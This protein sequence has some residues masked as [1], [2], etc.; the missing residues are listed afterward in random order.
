VSRRAA[1]FCALALAPISLRATDSAVKSASTAPAPANHKLEKKFE[2]IFSKFLRRQ[3]TI[4]NVTWR[5][6]P[7]RY[8]GTG[9]T[10]WE[11]PGLAMAEGPL[12]TFTVATLK[13]ITSFRLRVSEM[14]FVNA[15]GTLRFDHDGYVN[16]VSMIKDLGEY[17]HKNYKHGERQKVVYGSFRIENARVH[18]IDTDLGIEPFGAPLRLDARGDISGIGPKT[19]FPFHLHALLQSPQSPMDVSV[20]GTMS[21]WPMIR[22]SAEHIPLSAAVAYLPV[23]RWFS[24]EARASADF[25]KAGGYVF[26][27]WG[28]IAPA[29]KARIALPFPTIRVDAL[30]HEYAPSH[31]NVTLTGKATH[32]DA[33]VNVHDFKSKRIGFTL[34]GKDADIDECIQ[35]C[36]TGYWLN[37]AP[38]SSMNLPPESRWP[39]I[40]KISGKADI[41]AALSSVMGP[42]FAQDADGQLTIHIEKGR[43]AGMPGLIKAFTLLNLTSM[44]GDPNKPPNGLV[45]G[46]VDADIKIRHGVAQTNKP[47]VIESPSINLGVVG[48]VDFGKETIDANML[49]GVASVQ[50]AVIAHI[51]FV[52]RFKTDDKKGMIPIWLSIKGPIR[53]PE[54]KLLPLR[55]FDRDLW[56]WLPA[57]LQLPKKILNH[58]YDRQN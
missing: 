26:W 34:A 21:N 41:D 4:K 15:T 23:L 10:L 29:I 44:L 24:G 51:P 18:V 11:K 47:I 46:S 57:P 43:L 2:D 17:A 56:K 32:M 48:Q 58:I 19:L 31:L 5:L 33:R 30:F 53:D 54:I 42:R 3:L 16:V 7:L 40:W 38:A 9:I 13:T 6:F 8:T 52:R 39:V 27:K 50:E 28:V 49:I 55:T 1:F 12:A 20:S 14:R 45:F 35:W 22:L 36:R 25:A 37:E